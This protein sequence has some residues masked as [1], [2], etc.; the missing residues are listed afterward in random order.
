LYAARFSAIAGGRSELSRYEDWADYPEIVDRKLYAD[1]DKFF[2]AVESG[3][4]S[5]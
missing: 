1:I 5:L 4:F 2:A 3:A